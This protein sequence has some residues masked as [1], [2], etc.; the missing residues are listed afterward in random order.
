MVY[1]IFFALGAV[2]IFVMEVTIGQ[3]V[4]RGAMEVWTM[5]PLFKGL[6]IFSSFKM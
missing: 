2:P 1:G 5:C 3:Y 4:Q 6:H